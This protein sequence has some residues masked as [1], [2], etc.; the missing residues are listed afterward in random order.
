MLCCSLEP[1]AG[2]LLIIEIEFNSI[3][4][5]PT[6]LVTS[7]RV[8]T[9]VDLSYAELTSLFRTRGHG[10]LLLPFG[11]VHG[12]VIMET[13]KSEI[14]KSLI[15]LV[16][17]PPNCRDLS[18]NSDNDNNDDT[19]HLGQDLLFYFHYCYAS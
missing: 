1:E 9:S 6:P 17:S 14:G 11:S 12:Y 19:W 4:L 7:P 18:Y 5:T 8:R 3:G 10:C 2:L 13:G 16:R 15:V